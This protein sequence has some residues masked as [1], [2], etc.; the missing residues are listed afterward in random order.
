[1]LC[2][3]DGFGEAWWFVQLLTALAVASDAVAARL[4][5]QDTIEHLTR[6]IRGQDASVSCAALV[7]LSSLA[8]P[9]EN[10][11]VL[12]QQTELVELLKHC[13]S[14]EPP[15][16]EHK[17]RVAS[18]RALAVLGQNDLVD[19]AIGKRPISGRGLRV[20]ALD[21]GGMKG[22]AEVCILRAIEARTGH[23]I[24]E[25]FDVIGGTSTGCMLAMGAGVMRYSLNALEDVYMNL[26]RRV[27]A[28]GQDTKNTKSPGKDAQ[29]ESWSNALTRMYRSGEQSVRVAVYG[30]KYNARIF[31]ELT[32]ELTSLRELG[33]F[34]AVFLAHCCSH[35]STAALP[36]ALMCDL[37]SEQTDKVVLFL[38]GLIRRALS[39]C[40][41]AC[42]TPKE[43]HCCRSLRR[44]CP[45]DDAAKVFEYKDVLS[46]TRPEQARSFFK[47]VASVKSSCEVQPACGG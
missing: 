17:V 30:S 16:E 21:G 47:V 28:Q 8:F 23:R 4:L 10:K 40:E 18:V 39:C 7:A 34:S 32:Q 27:F 33:Y 31:E 46:C 44:R 35:T 45:L 19:A 41:D 1:L 2:H 15:A 37:I 14:T 13:A 25:L 43:W 36:Q 24:H 3:Q 22:M 26:G 6:L 42:F 29:S 12:L 11:A 38:A 5:C 20:L 9:E